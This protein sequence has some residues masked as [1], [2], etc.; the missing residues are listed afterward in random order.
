MISRRWIALPLVVATALMA[1]IPATQAVS[2]NTFT[3]DKSS[4]NPADIGTAT[5]VFLNDQG[6]LIRI[7]AVMMTFNYY[8]QDGRVYTQSFQVTG[9]SMNVTN[10][11]YSQSISV[12]FSLPSDISNGYF[13]PSFQVTFNQLTAGGV[14][15]GD[16]QANM[17]ATKPLYIQSPYVGLYQSAQTIEYVFVLAT[18]LAM[19]TAAYFA[20]HYYGSKKSP[21]PQN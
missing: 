4:Y 15:S 17:D 8:Y 1:L 3:L 10:G 7:T 20:I 16:R 18:V 9:M 2:L 13:L 5:T 6:A 19:A 12:K 11:S 21:I 14:W